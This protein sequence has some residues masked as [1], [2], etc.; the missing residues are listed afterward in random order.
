MEVANANLI[1]GGLRQ[2]LGSVVDGV[3]LANLVLEADVLEDS[4]DLVS[5]SGLSEFV[6]GYT[7]LV[8]DWR[9]Q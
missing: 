1:V 8:D 2:L 3:E 7:D 9:E 4:L 6:L 5:A